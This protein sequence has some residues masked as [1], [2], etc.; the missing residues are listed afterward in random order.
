[1]KLRR[2][3]LSLLPEFND[4]TGDKIAKGVRS[5]AQ[6]KFLQNIFEGDAHRLTMLGIKVPLKHWH[7][8]PPV[9][10][11]YPESKTAAYNVIRM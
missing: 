11:F 4:L 10:G 8:M 2:I 1:M 6:A 9:R 5:F 3:P 7:R